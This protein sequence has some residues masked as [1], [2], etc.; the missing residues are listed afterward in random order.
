MEG[1][2]PGGTLADGPQLGLR[3]F[4]LVARQNGS[5]EQSAPVHTHTRTCACV[6]PTAGTH[7]YTPACGCV[8]LLFLLHV[9][10]MYMETDLHTEVMRQRWEPRPALSMVP[11]R[12]PKGAL[13]KAAPCA[14]L[15]LRSSRQGQEPGSR[16][17]SG[18]CW[19]PSA[20]G[21]PLEAVWSQGTQ[22]AGEAVLPLVQG[23]G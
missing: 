10:S 14:G 12:L 7:L 15:E 11:S 8:F 6:C 22:E 5:A 13:E 2:H 17:P 23:G 19:K 21:W 4:V 3:A 20:L 1:G 18:G 16:Q 9:H